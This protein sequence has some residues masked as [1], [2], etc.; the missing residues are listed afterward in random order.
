MVCMRRTTCLVR[1]AWPEK[2]SRTVDLEA[3]SVLHRGDY[4][5]QLVP[6]TPSSWFEGFSCFVLHTFQTKRQGL[7]HHADER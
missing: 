4:L 2:Q 7:L 6:G 3:I 1:F 5:E